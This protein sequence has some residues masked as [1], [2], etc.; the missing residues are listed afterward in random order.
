MIRVTV[1]DEN[2]RDQ[3][4]YDTYPQRIHG[5][6]QEILGEDS[7][8]DVRVGTLDMPDCGL[9][10]ELL[11]TTDVLL[12]WGHEYHNRVPDELVDKIHRRVLAGMG[13]LILHSAHDSKI[14][15]KLMGTPCSL[16]WRDDEFERVWCVNPGHPIAKDVPAWFDLDC[17]EMYGEFFDIPQ[18]DELVF[19]GWYRGG[20]VMRA[21]CCWYRGAGKVFFF[22]PGHESNRSYYNPHVR[23]IIKNATRWAAPVVWRNNIGCKWSPPVE[24]MTEEQRTR[25]LTELT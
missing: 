12:W 9:P 7:D 14:F 10:D 21:G 15:K 8:F 19:M 16:R 11:D 3:A 24:G 13:I 2:R 22:Q 5:V 20:E 25:D 4:L 1:W 6:L 18:P 23:T 17:E